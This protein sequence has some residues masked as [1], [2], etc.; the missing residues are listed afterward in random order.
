MRLKTFRPLA[1]EWAL[2]VHAFA[3]WSHFVTLT[4]RR[5]DGKGFAVNEEEMGKAVRHFL[6]LLNVHLFKRSRVNRGWAIGTAVV[7]DW[8]PLGDHP[9]AHLLLEM[10]RGQTFESFAE[11]IQRAARRTRLFARQMQIAPY[12]DIGGS[13]YLLKHGKDRMVLPSL[14]KSRAG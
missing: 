12:R 14:V 3:D 7:I 4:I 13:R 2:W 1:E 5:H 10:P 9:H 8:G 6:R 11:L